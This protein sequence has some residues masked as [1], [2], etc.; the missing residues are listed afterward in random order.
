MKTLSLWNAGLLNP[1]R[2]LYDSQK[3]FERSFGSVDAGFVPACDVEE[4][5]SEFILSF[6][7]P[8]IK[9]DD[10][11]IEIHDQRLTVSGERKWE[12][13]KSDQTKYSIEKS[14]GRFERSFTLPTSINSEKVEARYEEG[15]LKL[16][17]PKTEVA[18]PR[19][20]RIV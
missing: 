13:K 1:L 14:Y 16:S 2:G 3:E 9:K 6:D 17:L 18:K 20:I 12:S 11:K 10:V 7:L 15:I 19:Q 8:G 4:N 5:D